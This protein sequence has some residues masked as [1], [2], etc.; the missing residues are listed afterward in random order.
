[1]TTGEVNRLGH[2]LRAS[3]PV[4]PSDL[5][6]LQDLRREYESALY[7]VQERV[8]TELPGLGWPTSRLKTVQTLVDKLRR[9][10]TMNLAQVQDIA[11]IR[12]VRP[13]SLA[14]QSEAVWQVAGLFEDSKVYDRRA[15]PSYGYRAVHVVVRDDGLPV[16][17]QLRTAMQDRWAQIVERMADQWGRRIRYGQGPDGPGQSAGTATRQT[18]VDLLRR[19]SPLI[20]ACEESSSA[21]SLQVKSNFYCQEVDDLLRELAKFPVLGSST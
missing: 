3:G 14:E 11:G 12:I 20:E 10:T 8:V 6:L 7:R 15:S 4:D 18:V 21:K 1:M 9:Q 13:M 2:R 19:L 5:N 16:E 17:V